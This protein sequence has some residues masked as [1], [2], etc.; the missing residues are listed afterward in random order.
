LIQKIL[1]LPASIYNKGDIMPK[2]GICGAKLDELPKIT[3][4]GKCSVCGAQLAVKK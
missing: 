1:I 3:E 4:E 2:C